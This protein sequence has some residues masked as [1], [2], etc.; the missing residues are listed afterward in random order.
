L[1]EM[2]DVRVAGGEM[3]RELYEF[4]DLI[5]EGCLDVLQPDAALVG[6]ITGLRRVALMA[7]EHNLLFTPHTW[8]NGVGVVA[9]AH[10]TAGVADAPFLEF[11]YD[12]PEWDVDRR[13]YMMVEPLKVDSAGN[14]VLT[15]RPG[16]GY[17][18]A[19]DMLAKTRTG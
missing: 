12:A 13:D 7:Q 16:M 6:G 18:L 1:R 17:E 3:T 10:L 5:A 8:T 2:V 9:N 4:R 11:P 19:E 14:I 15:D